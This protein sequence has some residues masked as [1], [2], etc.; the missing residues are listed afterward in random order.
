MKNTRQSA[1]LNLIKNNVIDTQEKLQ[2]ELR[3]LGFNVTQATVSRD[4]KA[5]NIIKGL[6][7]EGNYRYRVLDISF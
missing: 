7:G 4:I 3:E 6:D 2:Q 1:L 5:L